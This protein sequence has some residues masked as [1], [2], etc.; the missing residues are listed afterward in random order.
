MKSRLMMTVAFSLVT[1]VV[2]SDNQK[3]EMIR[4][5]NNFEL[6]KHSLSS[7]GGIISGSTYSVTASI[8]QLD[9]GHHAIGGIYQVN[10]G[11]LTADSDVIFK[12]GFE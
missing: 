1:T 10:G 4:G 12:H 8:A 3:Q 9:A 11:F 7:G 6:S 2:Y 5:A